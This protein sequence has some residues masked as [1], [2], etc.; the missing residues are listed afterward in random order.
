MASF[1]GQIYLIKN[2][3]NQKI[4]IGQTAMCKKGYF[5]SGTL[6]KLAIKKYG[7][8]NFEKKI[9]HDNISDQ[10][11]LNKLEI[12]YINLYN[13]TNSK[14]GYNLREGGKCSKF[15]H[16]EEA[17]EKIRKRSLQPDNKKR[18]KDIQK[19]AS[20]KNKGTKKLKEE[21]L[22]MIST[23]FG[24]VKE[25]EI[26]KKENN[27]LLYTCNF[28]TEASQLTGVKP[29]SIRN[30]LCGLSNSSGGYIFKYKIR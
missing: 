14:V 7:K 23:K 11:E 28:S 6:I 15:K 26:Y 16:T 19:K 20:E 10:E 18:I 21:K 4:Y 25:I 22:R 5:G 9:L 24:E 12:Y 1:K 27:N 30:N 29:S 2:K 8:I 13:S 17:K 3:I